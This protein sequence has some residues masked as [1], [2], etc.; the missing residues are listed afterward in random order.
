MTKMKK[1]KKTRV[2]RVYKYRYLLRDD[3]LWHSKEFTSRLSAEINVWIMKHIE[4]LD[5]V[6]EHFVLEEVEL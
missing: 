1:K 6:N 4:R 3:L 5:I 2:L